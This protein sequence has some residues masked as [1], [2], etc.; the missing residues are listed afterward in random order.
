[1]EVRE[2]LDIAISIELRPIKKYRKVIGRMG[3][4][5]Y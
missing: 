4:R 2:H 5:L 3:W 1:M